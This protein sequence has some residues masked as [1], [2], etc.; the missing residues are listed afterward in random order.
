MGDKSKLTLL[1]PLTGWGL[2]TE[3]PAAGGYRGVGAKPPAAGQVF[4]I[5]WKKNYFNATGLH[6][7]HFQSRLKELNF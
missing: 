5:L 3:L 1:K 7:A 2:G 6:F 4:V